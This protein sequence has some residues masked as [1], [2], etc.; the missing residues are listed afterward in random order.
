MSSIFARKRRKSPEGRFQQLWDSACRD[1][2]VPV[3]IKDAQPPVRFRLP[4]AENN[5]SLIKGAHA[6]K[7]TWNRNSYQWEVPVAWFDNLIEGC[8]RRYG[9]VYVVQLHNITEKCAPACRYAKGFDCVCACMGKNHGVGDG[10][11]DWIDVSETFSFSTHQ[12]FSCRHLVV[13]ERR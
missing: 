10:E 3:I 13:N 9:E 8:L 4:Y 5:R 1:G 11:G 2:G 7:P 6:R 12:N